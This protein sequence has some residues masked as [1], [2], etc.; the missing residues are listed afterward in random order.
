MIIGGC[1]LVNDGFIQKMKNDNKYAIVKSIET[2]FSDHNFRKSLHFL[3]K[4]NE[5]LSKHY[6]V[7]IQLGN[8]FFNNKVTFLFPVSLSD[9]IHGHRLNKH[10]IERITKSQIF[11][12]EV[13][14]F[15]IIKSL[16]K[17]IFFLIN[18]FRVPLLGV[19]YYF[20]LKKVLKIDKIRD[21]K[22]VILTPF[23]TKRIDNRFFRWVGKLILKL[24]F[25]EKINGFKIVDTYNLLNSGRFFYVDGTHLNDLGQVQLNS[26]ISEALS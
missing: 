1:H 14:L 5:Y 9:S 23:W 2:H 3:Q 11:N 15:L 12:L 16:T 10:H 6:D 13:I 21:N 26:I 7:C 20:Q 4:Q 19:R 25:R 22:I 8:L 24:T 18:F 17:F